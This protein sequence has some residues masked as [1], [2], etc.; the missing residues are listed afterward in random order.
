MRISSNQCKKS[1]MRQQRD[2]FCL[3]PALG[4]LVAK[5][6][7][8]QLSLLAQGGGNPD[9]ARVIPMPGSVVRHLG[10]I[11]VFFSEPVSGVESEDLSVNDQSAERVI[12]VG[13]GPY[14]F[15]LPQSV[16]GDVKFEWANDP[17]IES[18]EGDGN[19]FEGGGGWE[20]RLDPDAPVPDIVLNE[21]VATNLDGLRDEDGM[22]SDWVEIHNRGENAVDMGGWSLSDDSDEPGQSVLPEITLE[23]GDYIVVFASGKGSN[24]SFSG[25]PYHTSF[26]L[27]RDGEYL[28][29]F[30]EGLPREAADEI[31][32]PVQRA[33]YSYGRVPSGEWRYSSPPTPERENG[34]SQVLGVTDPPHFSVER[35]FF[36]RPF[37]LRMTAPAGVTIRYRTDGGEPTR[38]RGRRY[39][40]PIE[41]DETTF[42][43]AAAFAE[44]R[45]P[46]ETITHSYFVG[47]DHAMRSLPVLSITTHP[48]HLFGST[49]I[50]ET[51]PRNTTKH[52][53][54]WERPVSAELIRSDGDP[55]FQIDAGLRIHGGGY[56]RERYGPNKGLPFSK[57]SFRLY[58]RGDYGEPFLEYPWISEAPVS[59]FK[60][61][62]LR[63]GMNDHSNPFVVDELVRRLGS[64]MGHVNPQGTFV[65]LF[66]NGEYQG[67]YNPTER[68]DDW[69]LHTREGGSRNWDLIAQSGEIQEGDAQAWNALKELILGRD[70]SIPENYAKV[71][72]ELD[73]VNFIDYLILNI[74]VGT[75][76]WPHNNWRAARLK[77][78][79]AKFRFYVWDAEWAFG[80]VGRSLS[81]NVIEKELQRDTAIANFFHAL[82]QNPD[83]RLRFADR[84]HK[85]F[86]KGGALFSPHVGKRFK[87][88]RKTMSEVIPDM[89]TTIGNRW[90]PFRVGIVMGQLRDAGLTRSLSAPKFEPSPG[91]VAKGTEIE[92]SASEGGTIYY[93]KDGRDPRRSASTTIQAKKTLIESSAEKRVLVPL[94]ING[95]PALG[96]RWLGGDDSFDDSGWLEGHGAIGYDE[97]DNYENLIDTNVRLGMDDRNTSIFVRIPFQIADSKKLDQYNLLRLRVRYDDGFVAYL[98]GERVASANAPGDPG[99]DAS[100]VSGHSDSAAVQFQNFDL[101]QTMDRLKAG[102]NVLAI[103]GLNISLDSSDFLL[104]PELVIGR[105]Q[106]AEPAETARIYQGPQPLSESTTIHARTLQA[107]GRWSAMTDGAYRVAQFGSPIRLTELMYHPFENEAYQFIELAN[108]GHQAVDLSGMRFDGIDYV[109]PGGSVVAPGD[110]WVL[111]ADDD[112]DAFRARYSGVEVDGTFGGNLDNGGERLRLIDASGVTLVELEYADGGKWPE[113]ADG[114]GSSLVLA[115]PTRSINDPTNWRLSDRPA[116]SPGVGENRI[117]PNGVKLNELMAINESAVAR[118]DGH[119]DWIE[120]GNSGPEPATLDGWSLTDDPDEPRKTVLSN[121]TLEP[122]EHL[123]VW[124]DDSVSTGVTI[125]FRLDGDGEAVYLF[126]SQKRRVDAVSFGRQLTDYSIGRDS[127]GRWRLNRPTPGGQ[128]VVA[129]GVNGDDWVINEWYPGQ[130]GDELAWV[131]LYNASPEQPAA[132]DNLILSAGDKDFAVSGLAFYP[133][134]GLARFPAGRIRL[135]LVNRLTLPSPEGQLTLKNKAGELLDEV[136]YSGIAAGGSQGRLPDGEARIRAFP[137]NPTPGE[138]NARVEPPELRLNEVLALPETNS[139]E[140]ETPPSWIELFNPE[141]AAIS[142]EDFRLRIESS[143]RSREEIDFPPGSSIDAQGFLLVTLEASDEA[144]SSANRLT[145]SQELSP[146]GGMIRLVHDDGWMVDAVTYGHQ[147]RGR[148]LGRSHEEW[149][150]LVE[151]TPGGPNAAPAEL[152]S[153]KGLR[154]NEWLSAAESGKSDWLEVY[155]PKSKPVA[156]SGLF[157][158]DD[159]SLAGRDQYPIPEHSFIGSGQWTAWS[160]RDTG[161]GAFASIPF[162]LDRHGE[163]LRLYDADFQVIDEVG[164]GLQQPNS[165]KGRFPDGEDS[166]ASLV[167]SPAAENILDRDSDGMAD[168]W[169]ELNGLDPRDASDAKRDPDNDNR[170]NR[171]EYRNGTDPRAAESSGIDIT[172]EYDPEKG[173]RIHFRAEADTGYTV[174][175]SRSIVNPVWKPL[176]TIAPRPVERL[177]EVMEPLLEGRKRRFYRVTEQ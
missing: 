87:E 32:F 93:T 57:Y 28:G 3:K 29:L 25:P 37:T 113:H 91:N 131:E 55:G 48:E 15:K 35:G 1:R 42:I 24:A 103:Q 98:N 58:F 165:S 39:N 2:R 97:N 126:D 21:V 7:L 54:A 31:R 62:V 95:G 68:I 26:Q 76:D 41:I 138:P 13:K 122:G 12:G 6:A 90:A 74:Y 36:Q 167:P 112:P 56:V 19:A 118:G 137:R 46:S 64:D 65:N 89:D 119:P 109:F 53:K 38:T 71:K 75:G 116:G 79:G 160:G 27:S 100:A 11:E 34:Q 4:A 176:K 158:T 8:L 69:F 139:K 157:L 135:R 123:T 159:P 10:E 77:K 152:A 146:Q 173:I 134:G 164:F 127:E 5:L 120:L 155:N 151:P 44:D 80:N 83:F 166:L 163:M 143:G 156:M 84:V 142:L 88:L 73:I 162:G 128:N 140:S 115:D 110:H 23:P 114:E 124:A 70:L 81:V 72:Q 174:E 92:M 67:Y 94:N 18:L 96:D 16:T 78:P 149:A 52:G 20:V 47:E 99:W 61:V 49:G 101:S 130:T 106:S 85:H 108:T 60:R 30:S 104:E 136:E 129:S 147:V 14:T 133:P 51:D 177:E 22:T 66:L 59:R 107:N 121:V 33:G 144:F 170:T 17:G 132:L 45:L 148:S 105:R 175:F 171:M 169:E 111:I 102:R 43:R 150:L 172:A 153:P 117:E 168:N 161:E 145:F 86:S 125:D 141:E 40:G 63:A 9:V 154:L 50:M 82:K